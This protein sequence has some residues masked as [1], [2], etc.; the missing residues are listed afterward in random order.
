VVTCLRSTTPVS[1]Q[2][3]GMSLD[4]LEDKEKFAELI[5]Q[6]LDALGATGGDLDEPAIGEV[7]RRKFA[8]SMAE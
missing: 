5:A 3:L 1:A 2:M 6:G 7:G 8:A 4:V